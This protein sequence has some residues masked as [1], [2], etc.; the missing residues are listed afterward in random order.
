MQQWKSGENIF[1]SDIAKIPALRY[2][3][4]REDKTPLARFF[5]NSSLESRP[6]NGLLVQEIKHSTVR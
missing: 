1:P 4:G 3:S 2:R 5:L 6:L